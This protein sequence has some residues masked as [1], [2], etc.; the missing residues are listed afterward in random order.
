MFSISDTEL[1]QLFSRFSGLRIGVIGDFALDCY[2]TVDPAAALPSVETGKPT[3]PVTQQRYAAGA[4]GNVSADLA[5]L[6]CKQVA[7]FG[8]TGKDPWGEELKRILVELN[9]DVTGMICQ[10]NEWATVAYVKPH[11]NG[12]EQSRIDFGDFNRLHDSSTEKLL[13]ALNTA[14]PQ[15]DAVVINAQA[16]S[17]IHSPALREGLEKLITAYPEKIFT[18]DSREPETMYPGGILKINNLELARVCNCAADNGDAFL[19]EQLMK[20]LTEF[21]ALR[22]QTVF[23][24]C[25]AQGI[26]VCD[27]RG[28]TAV[29]AIE[30]DGEMDTTGAGDAAMAAITAAL[31]AGATPAQAALT[32]NL[33]AGVCIRKTH[34]TGT[35]TPAEMREVRAD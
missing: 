22:K 21:Y 17:G 6:G 12:T 24:T 28:I 29:P 26:I 4:A 25:G 2:W 35:A 16:R 3:N 13:A 14:L 8:V 23:V 34:Q 31:A 1:E 15:L 20:A 30:W 18:V 9:I 27:S 32:G 7:A 11:I 5:A 33:A 10:E 19:P